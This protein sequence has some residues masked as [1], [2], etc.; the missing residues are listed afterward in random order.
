M[1]TA[2]PSTAPVP[3]PSPTPNKSGDL[4]IPSQWRGPLVTIAVVIA[5]IVMYELTRGDWVRL[6][7]Y[8]DEC[9]GKGP[10][11]KAEP[12]S[13]VEMLRFYVM[14]GMAFLALL[15]LLSQVVLY[16]TAYFK[17]FAEPNPYQKQQ[18]DKMWTLLIG[19]VLAFAFKPEGDIHRRSELPT[20]SGNPQVAQPQAPAPMGQLPAGYVQLPVTAPNGQVIGYVPMPV[21]N[22]GCAGCAPVGAARPPSADGFTPRPAPTYDEPFQRK[23]VPVPVGPPSTPPST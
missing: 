14:L 7:Q 19:G 10:T 17:P 9:C 16:V 18:T 5:A 20:G 8:I 11:Y 21:F 6:V 3:A 1:S 15:F 12:L 13:V 22:N 23:P 4:V 2:E